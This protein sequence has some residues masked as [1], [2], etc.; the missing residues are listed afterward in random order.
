M[1]ELIRRGIYEHAQA[2]DKREYSA[3]ELTR[4]YLAEIEKREPVV[5]AYL[6]LDPEAA[7]RDAAASDAR[8]AKGEARGAFDGI[9]YA[10]KDNFCTEGLRTTC[11][12]R[13][14]EHFV[15]S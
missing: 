11:A 6:T 12:S 5:G 4:A 8:R 2:L 14:L 7:L 9:P 13:M 1:T 10:L 15:P 3:T